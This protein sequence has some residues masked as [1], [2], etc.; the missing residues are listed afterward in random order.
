M[1]MQDEQR[2]FPQDKPTFTPATLRCL[3]A[4]L[5]LSQEKRQVASRSIAQVLHVKPP[6]I[7]R[8]LEILQQDGMIRKEPYGKVEL[9]PKGI[10]TA[11]AWRGR[12]RR[13][14][15]VMMRQL[16]LGGEESLQ[17]ALYFATSMEEQSQLNM[18]AHA[19]AKR[20]G[21]DPVMP[22]SLAA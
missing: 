10:Q 3:L 13:L 11:A 12:I 22:L 15:I 20:K 19:A 18:I 4:I 8:I 17:A 5:K 6:S 1:A 21:E 14:Q 7:C 16:G 9:T 2:D